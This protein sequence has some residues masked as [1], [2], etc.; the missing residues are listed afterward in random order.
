[1]RLH[2]TPC[3]SCSCL[4]LEHH[5]QEGMTSADSAHSMAQL[6][7]VF[8]TYSLAPLGSMNSKGPQRACESPVAAPFGG[9]FKK[10][11]S[12]GRA[13][14]WLNGCLYLDLKATR[15]V[16]HRGA[17]IQKQFRG[18]LLRRGTVLRRSRGNSRRVT[19][20]I[21]CHYTDLAA[22]VFAEVEFI[23]SGRAPTLTNVHA[24]TERADGVER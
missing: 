4:C 22:S 9:L 17:E 14:G 20:L 8:K 6:L 24:T 12:L 11:T 13:T 3:G 16:S 2:R 23:A 19:G 5:Q 18:R 21:H 10:G 15:R 1:M 7:Q